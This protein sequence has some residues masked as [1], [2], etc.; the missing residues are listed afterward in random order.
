MRECKEMIN[1]M[2]ELG[3]VT[4]SY[5]TAC[6]IIKDHEEKGIGV[7]LEDQR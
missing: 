2:I 6:N 7:K 4:P 5:V 3:Y 1:C